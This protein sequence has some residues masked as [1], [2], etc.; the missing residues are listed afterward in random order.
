LFAAAATSARARPASARRNG[1]AG[2][3]PGM[4]AA[5]ATATP[6]HQ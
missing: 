2:G 4:R 1:S 5:D 3:C 6:C